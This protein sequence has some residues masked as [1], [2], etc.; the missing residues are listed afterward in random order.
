MRIYTQKSNFFC[1]K[2]R[3]RRNSSKKDTLFLKLLCHIFHKMRY[4]NDL[5]M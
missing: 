1:V 4:D 3:F 5:E 2:Q